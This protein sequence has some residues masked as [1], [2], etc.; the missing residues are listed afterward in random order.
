V[1]LIYLAQGRESWRAVVTTLIKFLDWLSDNFL[2]KRDFAPYGE[3]CSD[4]VMIF[5]VT[6]PFSIII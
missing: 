6:T 2:P 1:E 4:R 5:L 3:I